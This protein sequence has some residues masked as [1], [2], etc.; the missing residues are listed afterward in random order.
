MQGVRIVSNVRHM[1]HVNRYRRTRMS[2]AHAC[3]IDAHRIRT[4]TRGIRIGG[5]SIG[6]FVMHM[7]FHTTMA[8][9][10]CTHMPYT[11]ECGHINMCVL[12]MRGDAVA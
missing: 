9:S 11:S 3:I 6:A 8:V 10:V 4:S 12:H 5:R 2:L 1:E 7:R